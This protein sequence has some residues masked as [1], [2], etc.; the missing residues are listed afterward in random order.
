MPALT[1]AF[2]DQIVASSFPERL[3]L[4]EKS[5]IT[6]D[7]V[8]HIL[9]LTESGQTCLGADHLLFPEINGSPQKRSG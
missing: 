2:I 6:D 8:A 4:E 1:Q 7:H 3:S 9:Q 5:P